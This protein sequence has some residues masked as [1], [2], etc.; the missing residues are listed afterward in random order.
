[1]SPHSSERDAD[2]TTFNTKLPMATL[3]PDE[4]VTSVT[5][6]S[7]AFALLSPESYVGSSLI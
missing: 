1:M 6:L 4:A 2:N 3:L 5:D 7:A